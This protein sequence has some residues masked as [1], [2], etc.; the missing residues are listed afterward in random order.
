MPVINLS[1]SKQSPEKK[2]A[3]IK[4]LTKAASTVTGINEA[5][6]VVTLTEYENENIGVGGLDLNEYMKK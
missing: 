3:L 2:K 5:A 1:I 6:F 4:E